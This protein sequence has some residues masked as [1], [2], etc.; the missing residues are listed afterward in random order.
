MEYKTAFDWFPGIYNKER[1]YNFRKVIVHQVDLSRESC[2][3]YSMYMSLEG[4]AYANTD[5]R[6]E[7]ELRA[8]HFFT[9]KKDCHYIIIEDII[10]PRIEIPKPLLKSCCEEIESRYRCGSYPD[11]KYYSLIAAAD[12]LKFECY[13]VDQHSNLK[14]Q[15]VAVNSL[16]VAFRNDNEIFSD[17]P[18]PN[19]YFSNFKNIDIGFLD[20][21]FGVQD[22]LRK[23]FEDRLRERAYDSGYGEIV[24]SYYF[25]D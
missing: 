14:N 18:Q 4:D 13:Y 19:G 3:G 6:Y 23:I 17:E 20:I 7:G 11:L 16:I 21:V 2:D 22:R 24:S 15:P 8:L 25:E 10:I 12:D 9:M 5:G 1:Y